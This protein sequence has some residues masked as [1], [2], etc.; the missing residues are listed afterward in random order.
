MV[1]TSAPTSPDL[2]SF[3]RRKSE[4]DETSVAAVKKQRTR[5]S[6]SCGEC[7]RRKQK[8]DRQIPCSHCVTRRVPDLCKPYTPGKA[9]QDLNAR[10]MRL[11]HIIQTA[12][13]QY[14]SS[15]S[16]TSSVGAQVAGDQKSSP[17]IG[18]DD[19]GSQTEEH[20]PIGGTFQSGNWYGNSVS[21]SVAPSSILEQLKCVAGP[22]PP[23]SRQKDG[24]RIT[25]QDHDPKSFDMTQTSTSQNIGNS[26]ALVDAVGDVMGLS[27]ARNFLSLLQDFGF[28]SQKISEL[29]QELPPSSVSD[30]LIDFYF[31]TINWTRYPVC[32]KSF[33]AA[34][35]AFYAHVRDGIGALDASDVRFL[36]L[37][38]VVIAISSR[39][40]PEQVAGDAFAKRSRSIRYYWFSRRALLMA[41][42]VQS[43]SLDIVLTRLLSARFLTFDRRITECWSQLGAA[44]RTAQALGLHRD[45]STMVMEPSAVEYRRRIWSYLYHADRSYALVL[46]RPNSIQDD[47]TST[48]PPSN[49]DDASSAS[50]NGN[51]PPLSSP[52]RMTFVI[53]RHQLAII[54]GRIAHHFQRVRERSHYSEVITLDDEL[55]SFVNSLPPHFALN[56]NK[57]LDVTDTYIPVHRYLLLTEI[58]FVRINLHRPY[59][60]RR[61]NSHRYARSRQACFESAIKDFEI[62][63]AFCETV[64]REARESLS[65][66]YRNFQTA[67]IGGIY[68]ILEPDGKYIESMRAILDGFIEERQEARE[69]D[70]TTRRELKII[71]FLRLKASQIESLEPQCS[72]GGQT[73]EQQ[74]QLLLGLQQSGPTVLTASPS[75]T[76][77][78]QV[79]QSLTFPRLHHSSDVIHSPTTSA[80]PGNMDDDTVAQSLLDHWCS[81]VSNA[82]VDASTGAMSWGGPGGADFSGWVQPPSINGSDLRSLSGLEDWNYWEALVNQIQRVP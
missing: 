30:A 11:E 31:S 70:E 4:D 18:D 74:A 51:Y 20:D 13:P 79:A 59:F 57:S 61:L 44:V 35:T 25:V 22:L 81:T 48:Q 76:F 28:S 62:R 73:S 37:L 16:S 75:L 71:E 66:A 7:H 60:L 8:C 40:A 39:L 72:N 38:F 43:D 42:A 65:N 56:P 10:I 19:N 77:S 69:M 67:M 33:R 41:A 3:K 9:D 24:S 58:M 32:E 50:H 53:L 49:I 15:G 1:K 45:G 64:P 29:L 54:M 78:S 68:F 55:L 14:W 23:G 36:P 6:F 26:G 21:G 80:S 52:T 17:S 46:G 27:A 47:Y 2:S 34:Y 82:P 5:V 12:L 63:R